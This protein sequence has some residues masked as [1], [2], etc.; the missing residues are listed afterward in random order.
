MKYTFPDGTVV[1][2]SVEK[3]KTVANALGF[4]FNTRGLYVSESRGVVRIADMDSVHLRNALL[5]KT[6]EWAADLYKVPVRDLAKVMAEGPTDLEYADL[7][8]ELAQ[9]SVTGRI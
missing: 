1:E 4:Q 2:G 9:R 7:Y 3:I 8:A 5:K 6:R